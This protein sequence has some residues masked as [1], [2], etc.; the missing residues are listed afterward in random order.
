MAK[1][2]RNVVQ[3]QKGL[4]EPAFERRSRHRGAMP[5][6]RHYSRTGRHGFDAV[7]Y[8][9]RRRCCVVTTR[10]ADYQCGKCRNDRTPSLRSPGTIFWQ[11]RSR[12]ICRCG[13]GFWAIYHLTQTKQGIS[14]ACELGRRLGVTQTHRLARSNTSHE[15]GDACSVMRPS[16]LSG[17]DRDRRRLASSAMP[18]ALRGK[19]HGR[20]APGKTPFVADRRDDSP[21]EGPVRLDS[22]PSSIRT[23]PGAGQPAHCR[24]RSHR[25]LDPDCAVVSERP[26]SVSS[27]ASRPCRGAPAIRSSPTEGQDLK[28][29]RT[30]G[31][32]N[33]QHRTRGQHQGRHHRNLP[34]PCNSKF[35]LAS[36]TSPNVEAY[37]L[38][39]SRTI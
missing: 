21:K 34:R 19:A 28:A 35:M 2:A 13:Y 22:T 6:N 36:A 30:A 25:S 12:D 10:D 26:S 38:V 32:H 29:A 3:F 4:S 31:V 39:Q 7:R 20:G 33:G 24:V 27:H 18:N 9:V 11:N 23:S 17:S 8:A 16:A 15:A 14:A 37:T 5:G 1:L